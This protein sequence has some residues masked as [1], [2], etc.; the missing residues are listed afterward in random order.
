[1]DTSQNLVLNRTGSV[2][3]T[4]SRFIFLQFR[5]FFLLMLQRLSIV[6]LDAIKLQKI[7]ASRIIRK[8]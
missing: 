6:L 5:S 1:M 7:L 4:V 8:V 3:Q 2:N